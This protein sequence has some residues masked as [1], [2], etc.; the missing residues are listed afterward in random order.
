MSSLPRI[1][2]ITPSFQ[3]AAYLE[4]CLRSVADQGYPATEHIVIDGGS[5]DGSAEL[6]AA[7]A[8]QLAYWVSE[9]D[10]GQSDAINKGLQHATGD[11]FTWVN[12]DDA[13]L[14]GALERAGQAFANDPQLLAFG[15]T[16]EYDTNGVRH[17]TDRLNGKDALQLHAE[18][19]INQPATYLRMD[20]VR[21]LG[22]VET[23][24]RYVMDLELW[25]QLLF[26]HGTEAL[27][28]EPVPL[29]LFRLHETSKTTTSQQGFL[30]ETAALLNGLCRASGND[31]LADALTIGHKP[32]SGLRTIP[33]DRSHHLLVR[34]MAV[35][36]L[37]KWNGTIH[38]AEQFRMMQV[39][40]RSLLHGV[41]YMPGMEER[42][43][44]LDAQLAVR[45]WPLFR[46]RRKWQ[47]LG[48]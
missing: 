16:L 43:P 44:A 27:R 19:V 9:Q 29:A 45:W 26:H 7:H 32:I 23:K 25:W 12:S 41:R 46:L 5:T 33:A 14:P 13:L 31:D 47:H 15:G 34:S 40:R 36:F 8:A 42:L 6:I 17:R 28:F 10:R 20:A 1:S 11:V 39:F 38:T 21:A 18:P 30:D 24:L 35:H 37:L 22:G 2:I 48:A 4:E 3:Q